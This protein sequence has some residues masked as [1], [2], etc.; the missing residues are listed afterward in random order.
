VLVVLV[1]SVARVVTAVMVAPGVPVAARAMV[2]LPVSRVRWVWRLVVALV[3]S[4]VGA[5]P[6][7]TRR[8]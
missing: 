1:V 3:V 8:V 2:V 4:A 7:S 6:G 5:V